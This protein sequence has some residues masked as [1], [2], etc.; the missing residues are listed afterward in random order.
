[1]ETFIRKNDLGIDIEYT[2]IG[3]YKDGKND[4][5]IY[6]DFVTD[7]GNKVGIRLFVDQEIGEQLVRLD[8][9]T[10][11]KIITQFNKDIMRYK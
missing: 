2:V 8:E 7:N 3:E 1:M 6:T 5:V 9:V 11:K 10:E 4:Y